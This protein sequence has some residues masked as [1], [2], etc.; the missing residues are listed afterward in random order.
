MSHRNRHRPQRSTR[1]LQPSSRSISCSTTSFSPLSILEYSRFNLFDTVL[2]TRRETSFWNTYKMANTKNAMPARP[3]LPRMES[4]ILAKSD[5]LL[6]NA[7]SVSFADAS[8]SSSYADRR[9]M[10]LIAGIKPALL[11]VS[12]RHKKTSFVSF[13]LTVLIR[14]AIHLIP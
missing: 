11:A 14:A 10:R 12:G 6:W 5:L 13:R 1:H 4:F 2:A 8:C 3:P 9:K 7:Y